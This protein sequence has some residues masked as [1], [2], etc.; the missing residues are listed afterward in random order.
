MARSETFSQACSKVGSFSYYN[1]FTL[2]V[3][4]TDRDGNSATNKSYTDYKVYCSSNGAGSLNSKH[5]IYFE[6]DGQI[7]VNQTVT[8]SAS[9]PYIS[10]LIAQG[11]KE[12]DHNDKSS[13]Y[14]NA[15]IQASSYGVSAA[16]SGYFDLEYI[17]RY[18]TV[19]NSERGKTLNTISINWSTA[20]ARDWTQFS[21]NDGEWLNAYDTVASDNKSGYYTI[22]NLEPNTTY[23]IRTRCRRTDSGLWS[24]A[25]NLWIRTYDIARITEAPNFTDEENPTIKYLNPF[26][27]NVNELLACI[28]LNGTKDDIAYKQISKTGNSYTFEL[29]EE[30][31]ELLREATKSNTLTVYFYIK[32]VYGETY[33][34][35]IGR[36]FTI[37]NGNPIFSNFSYEDVN[38]NIVDNLTGDNQTIIKGYSNVRG[39]V[40]V[41]NKAI[42]QKQATM[43]KYRL[44]IGE[45][46][47]E[48]NY[49]DTEDV[50][51]TIEKA[52]SNIITMYAIDSR[53]NSTAK[54]ITAS[55]FI[56]YKPIVIKTISV[57]RKGNIQEETSLQFEGSIWNGN[58]G[59]KS[60]SINSCYYR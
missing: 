18:T 28:S 47:S 46:V 7:I 6:L 5:A 2:Y 59:I 16:R 50:S 22:H 32:T 21:L 31:R 34:N 29:T 38:Q 37:I 43:N 36:T 33:Y 3:E 1:N 54:Q 39:L 8:W 55:K 48:V 40:S 45:A 53:E 27:N 49:S 30:E 23:K 51:T 26:G 60:N 17:P 20:D 56:D 4:L 24:E 25:G 57:T 14:F 10:I 35:S 19:W 11:T 41:A 13:I 52:T 12:I 58:F 44:S 15:W 42:P 9:S